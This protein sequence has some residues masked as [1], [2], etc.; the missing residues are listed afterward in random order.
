M[1]WTER[2]RKPQP[3]RRWQDIP[4]ECRDPWPRPYHWPMDRCQ[5]AV[6]VYA[7]RIESLY[8]QCRKPVQYGPG[9]LCPEH[10]KRAARQEATA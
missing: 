7:Y 6:R 8:Y 10:V 4:A 3:F 1:P 5:A 2:Q 9:D